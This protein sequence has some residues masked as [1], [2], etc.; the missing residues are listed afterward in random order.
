MKASAGV[1]AASKLVW[2]TRFRKCGTVIKTVIN[3]E[4]KS[5]ES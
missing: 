5:K 1:V 4:I 2:R 3:E